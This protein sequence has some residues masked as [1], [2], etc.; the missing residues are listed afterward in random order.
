MSIIRDFISVL[1]GFRKFTIMLLLV[2]IGVSFRLSGHL[3]GSEMVSLLQATAVAFM[4]ANG[5]EHLTK[6]VTEW[7]KNKSK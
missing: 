6:S 1:S 7:V 2:I 5:I 3:S 4:S